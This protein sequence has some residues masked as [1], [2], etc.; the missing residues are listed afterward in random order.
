MNVHPVTAFKCCLSFQYKIERSQLGSRQLQIS[1]WHAGALKYRVF[2]GEVVIP[3]AAWSFE[4]SSMGSFNWY[5]LQSKVIV[6]L[7]LVLAYEVGVMIE[8][9]E[10]D[11]PSEVTGARMLSIQPSS[12]TCYIY[13]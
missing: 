2:L 4:D 3:L 8:H 12:K 5:Q 10:R 1:V 11:C 7:C 13:K 6:N 9:Y